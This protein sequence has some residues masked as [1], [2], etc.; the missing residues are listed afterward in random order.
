MPAD[1]PLTAPVIEFTVATAVLADV[2][3]PPEVVFVNVVVE[4]THAFK[5]PP[6][7]ASVGNG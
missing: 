7:G 1:T 5:T 4:P 2:H 6:I 3:A